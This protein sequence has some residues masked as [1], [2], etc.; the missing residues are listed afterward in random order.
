MIV[1]AQETQEIFFSSRRE[2]GGE[3][4]I[5]GEGGNNGGQSWI[6]R[7]GLEASRGRH[8]YKYKRSKVQ[9]QY[10]FSTAT[11]RRRKKLFP[12][13]IYI[14]VNETW[15]TFCM[16]ARNKKKIFFKTGL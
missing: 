9:D 7:L 3:G 14:N 2:C 1:T 13:H 5:E 6:R 10:S 8:S 11:L 16:E 4:G 15:L 12:L